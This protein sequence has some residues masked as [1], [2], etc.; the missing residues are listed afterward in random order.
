MAAYPRK[1]TVVTFLLCTVAVLGVAYYVNGESILPWSAKKTN[2]YQNVSAAPVLAETFAIN[3]DWKK[4]FLDSNSTSTAFRVPA[5]VK[6]AEKPK[7]LTATDKL[8]REFMTRY[9]TLRQTG[10]A[11]DPASVNSAMAQV[12]AENIADL[13]TPKTYTEKNIKITSDT[14]P[15]MKAY[16]EGISYIIKTFMPRDNEFEIAV[17]AV[18][19][20]KS[21]S[22]AKIDPI[23]KNYDL[24][25]SRLLS[26]PVPNS[27][28]GYHLDLINGLSISLY[29]AKALRHID[30][31]PVKALGGISFVTIGLEGIQSAY[32]NI[33]QTYVRA[34]I[35]FGV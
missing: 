12:T 33:Q 22:L 3:D 20:G 26:T 10:L 31:D 9:Y 18:E 29:A 2:Y 6:T 5:V 35:P 1:Q 11:D 25:I 21:G 19:Q 34:G 13:P 14:V 24:M 30:S 15:A 32:S 8:G 4:Q 7:P 17:T 23:I 28:A 16:S 27:V